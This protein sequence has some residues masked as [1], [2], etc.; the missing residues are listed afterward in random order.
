MEEE[1]KLQL[2]DLLSGLEGANKEEVPE[3]L[4]TVNKSRSKKIQKISKKR[5]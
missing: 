4:N 5:Q 3:F 2:S 1:N